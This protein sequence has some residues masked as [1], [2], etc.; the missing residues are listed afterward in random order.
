[1]LEAILTKTVRETAE[2]VTKGET[3]AT[4]TEEVIKKNHRCPERVGSLKWLVAVELF[5]KF[6]NREPLSR[7]VFLPMARGLLS[8]VE[9]M[10]MEK[11][12]S[13]PTLWAKWHNE[14]S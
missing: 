3:T 10:P 12:T 5:R 1:M 14:N 9:D 2:R 7:P 11:L 4:V 6:L 8:R 13:D